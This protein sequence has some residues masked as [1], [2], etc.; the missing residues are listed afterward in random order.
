[1][2]TIQ[3][4]RKQAEFFT[5][6][7][8]WAGAK[9]GVGSG[10]TMSMVWWMLQRLRDYPRANHVVV[11]SDYD[12]LR[13]GFF[14]SLLGVLEEDLRWQYGLD[15]SYR[16]NPTPMIRLPSGARLRSMSAELAQ[17]VRSIEIQ[18]LYC[19]EPQ[20]WHNGA[21]A[22]TFRAIASRLRHSRITTQIYPDMPLQGRM[23]F[24]PPAVGT[25][26]HQLVTEQWAREAYPL[27]TFSLRD[28]LLLR[29]R[30]EYIAQLEAMYPPE[31]WPVEIDGEWATIGGD[32]YRGFDT[33]VHGMDPPA[34]LPKIALDPE[35]PLM[36]SLDFNV[37]W[38]ASVVCQVYAQRRISVGFENV[39]GKPPRQLYANEVPHWQRD[40]IYC[41]DE[42]FLRDSGVPDAL[43][44]FLLRYGEIAKRV[45]VYLYGDPAGGARAQTMSAQAAAKSPWE[46]ILA[47]LISAKIPVTV[48][49]RTAAPAVID[50]INAVR[51]Q[52]RTGD[53]VGFVVDTHRCPNLVT[54]FQAVR[55][56]PG[57]NEIDKDK[58][59]EQGRK[60]THL[61]DALGY[62]IDVHR[63]Q[64][65]GE[66]L[67]FQGFMGR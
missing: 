37:G 67:D 5:C 63:R 60:L 4:L 22:D 13:R 57:T 2:P 55:F 30:E 39:P 52:F 48:C 12:Q 6:E 21:G 56:K 15:F 31:Q 43:A 46:I 51:A 34:P 40:V 26:L 8:R 11:G 61:S 16:E 9:G 20:T 45:G 32:V 62:L 38:M 65:R 53:G 10:K 29:G 54:D 14:P 47:G 27:W 28:N 7:R 1:M 44:E 66:R 59:T 3:M 49:V 36:W 17:R 41:L 64:S 18:S 23:T 50:R 58:K 35:R 42:I 33:T 19:E 24:N 25:W